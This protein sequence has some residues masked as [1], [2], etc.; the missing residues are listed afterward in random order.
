MRICIISHESSA[1][2]AVSCSIKKHRAVQSR[3][4]SDPDEI[5]FSDCDLIAY[6][7]FF[8]Q[9]LF[10]R[11]KF[12]QNADNGIFRTAWSISSSECFRMTIQ[13]LRIAGSSFNFRQNRKMIPIRSG[14]HQYHRLYF[15]SKQKPCGREESRSINSF[16]LLFFFAINSFPEPINIHRR[17]NRRSSI[18]LRRNRFPVFMSS[19]GNALKIKLP[20]RF[21]KS[22]F[23]LLN[24]ISVPLTGKR[25]C[26]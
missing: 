8:L 22:I 6:I 3:F 2:G 10:A 23:S 7:S 9:R 13:P 26:I 4:Y 1:W 17:E 16:W 21:F 15:R 25:I 18:T 19:S 20:I 14:R 11:F 24:N 5:P 12:Q